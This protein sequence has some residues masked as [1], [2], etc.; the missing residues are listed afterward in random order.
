M[1]RAF[2]AFLFNEGAFTP[3]DARFSL[4][5]SLRGVYSGWGVY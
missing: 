4:K 3:D 5:G 1:T 2:V